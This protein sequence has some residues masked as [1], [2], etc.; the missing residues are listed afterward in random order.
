MMVS[1]PKR[2]PRSRPK[3][4]FWKKLFPKFVQVTGTDQFAT[5]PQKHRRMRYQYKTG[6]ET[7][8]RSCSSAMS[9]SHLWSGILVGI[10]A[11]WASS[12]WT[13]PRTF[14]ASLLEWDTEI[15]VLHLRVELDHWLLTVKGS[16]PMRKEAILSLLIISP[17]IANLL[18]FFCYHSS[19]VGFVLH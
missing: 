18:P 13:D 6:L 15:D 17:L 9:G 10:E 8:P 1:S 12:P 2:R 11:W 4:L 14:H 7:M 3:W 16:S 5:G 19:K